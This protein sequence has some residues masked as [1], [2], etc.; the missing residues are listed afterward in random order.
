MRWFEVCDH[1]IPIPTGDRPGVTLT[2]PGEPDLSSDVSDADT[3]HHGTKHRHRAEQTR[4]QRVADRHVG[5]H[6]DERRIERGQ[7]GGDG[8]GNLMN[9]RP[10]FAAT[11]PA[12]LA[13]TNSIGT[14]TA[15]KPAASST[16]NGPASGPPSGAP[17]S[18]AN[19]NS[20]K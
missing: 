1:A 14:N 3:H 4:H 18:E 10:L 7:H 8:D 9:S 20:P 5:G 13:G 6:R 16:S 15:P 12:T 17:D 19:T 11:S 2:H